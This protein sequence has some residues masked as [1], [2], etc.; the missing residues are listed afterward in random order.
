MIFKNLSDAFFDATP[1]A[2]SN[3][4]LEYRSLSGP[5]LGHG[6]SAQETVFTLRGDG[7]LEYRR[8][9]DFGERGSHPP[10]HWRGKCDPSEVVAAW[11]HVGELTEESFPSRASDPGDTVNRLTAFSGTRIE[12]LMWGPPDPGVPRPGSQFLA[13]LGPL[14]ARAFE[15]TLW[16]LELE[17][18]EIRSDGVRIRLVGIANN[19]GT[20]PIFLLLP[21]KGG[22]DGFTLR[23]AEEKPV[24]AGKIP[25]PVEWSSVR[26]ENPADTQEYLLRL[27]G[28]GS[29]T[30]ELAANFPLVSGVPYSGKLSYRQTLHLDSYASQRLVTGMAFSDA[31]NFHV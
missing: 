11:K 6:Q 16:S 14:M 29:T 25:L 21:R 31:Q 8:R 7:T 19:S 24:A 9:G 15:V 10:G 18:Q 2:R 17:I 27:D 5:S 13:F 28:G 22:L 3:A 12:T 20:E 30:I 4:A 1:E 26:L 23:Y